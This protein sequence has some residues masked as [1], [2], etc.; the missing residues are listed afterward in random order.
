MTENISIVYAF[1]FPDDHKCNYT[2]NFRRKDMA[3][4]PEF[5]EY[6]QP[7]WTN[8]D[9]HQC[10]HC[11]LQR[12]QHPFCPI[13]LNIENLVCFFK[14]EISFNQCDVKVITEKR[15]YT[16]KVTLQTGLYS[17]LGLIMA[18]SGC[19][20]MDFLRPMAY[21][22]LPFSTLEET[23]IRAISLYLLKQYFL[24]KRGKTPDWKLKELE[25]CYDSVKDVN[26]GI[27]RRIRSIKKRGDADANAII[28]LDCFASLLQVGISEGLDDYEDI[29]LNSLNS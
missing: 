3:F 11:P 16:Q 17:I 1:H 28:V 6:E 7:E 26:S 29:F 12:Q 4:I 20:H 15:T 18:T 2:M 22:H 24:W 27:L 9:F 21:F 25:L 23:I 5:D 13:A 10:A 19:P 8:L 14:D